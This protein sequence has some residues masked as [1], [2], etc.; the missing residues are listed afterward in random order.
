M[1]EFLKY[2]KLCVV[3]FILASSTRHRKF[4][5]TPIKEW[6]HSIIISEILFL[7]KRTCHLPWGVADKN[8]G[9]STICMS[10]N[11]WSKEL[12]ILWG[13]WLYNIF[14]P[15][16]PAMLKLI[17][18]WPQNRQNVETVNSLAPKNAKMLKLTMIF[19]FF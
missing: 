11:T 12:E 9:C 17:Q 19:S 6:H 7:E 1:Q 2:V 16:N 4:Q 8:H 18:F 13:V 15:Q 10:Y 5:I 3:Y 14:Y